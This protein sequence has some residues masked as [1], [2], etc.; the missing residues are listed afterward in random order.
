[1]DDV[2]V[3]ISING[4]VELSKNTIGYIGENKTRNLIIETEM[5]VDD[6]TE[7]YLEIR[8]HDKKYFIKIQEYKTED[9]KYVVPIY[10]SILKYSYIQ[11]QFTL[12]KDDIVITKSEIFDFKIDNSINTISK[13]IPEDYKVWFVVVDERISK[14]ED[15]TKK[16]SDDLKNNYYTKEETYSKQEVDDKVSGI[17]LKDYLKTKDADEK[18]LDKQTASTTYAT[19]DE[20]PNTKDFIKKDVTDLENYYDKTTSDDKYATKQ[21]IPD[22]KN[23][24]TKAVDDLEN[25]YKKTET[26]TQEEINQRISAIKTINLKLVDVL[27]E[28]GESNYIY[29]V[30]SLEQEENN[31]KNEYIWLEEEQSFELI[32]TTKINLDDYINTEKLNTALQDY[33]KQSEITFSKLESDTNVWELEEGNYAV[34]KQLKLDF[35]ANALFPVPMA[36]SIG[37]IICIAKNALSNSKNYTILLPNGNIYVG[38]VTSDGNSLSSQVTSVSRLITFDNEKQYSV[39]SDYIPAHKNY[40]DTTVSSKVD[41]ET[42]DLLQT[43]SRELKP[44]EENGGFSSQTIVNVKN[45]SGATETIVEIDNLDVKT[46][47]PTNAVLGALKGQDL[48]EKVN[49]LINSEIPT[50]ELSAEIQQSDKQKY[51]YP[52]IT[53]DDEEKIK[54]IANNNIFNMKIKF[55]V[56]NGNLESTT[57]STM[58]FVTS[59]DDS[60]TT[61]AQNVVHNKYVSAVYF[62]NENYVCYTGTILGNMESY[63]STL[64]LTP[65]HIE[66]SSG[67]YVTREEFDSTVGNMITT[68][69]TLTSLL[70]KKVSFADATDEELAEILD[71]HYKGLINIED[72]WNVGDTRKMHLSAMSSGTGASES[73][74]EQDMTMVIIGFNHDDLKEPINGINKSAITLQCKEVLGNNG[75]AEWVY[76][77]GSSTS[78][79]SD[80]NYSKNPRRTWLNDTFVNSLPSAIQPLVKTVIKKNINDHSSSPSAGPDTEDKAFLTSYPEMFGSASY[81]N[82][83]GS[84]MLEGEQY[85]YYNSNAKR[86]KFW[87]KNGVASGN[88]SYYW[89]R[90]PSSYNSY[91]WI[92]VHSDGSASNR[93]SND[94]YGLAPAFCL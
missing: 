30:P 23:F 75:S 86:T 87:N 5:S 41:E 91:S 70:P 34:T 22:V 68:L 53:I 19:K 67:D 60:V 89:L 59:V 44:D 21:E 45:K 66:V 63:G 7:A 15:D 39:Y 72:Y 17:D 20:I 83:K 9:N 33:A 54:F 52:T 55:N 92:D 62:D 85:P 14:V 13:E 51:I 2:N 38:N 77:W 76:I 11:M 82:Y 64:T 79:V 48:D 71:A 12:I 26:Y 28:Q 3:K 57:T 50:L 73:H 36:M 65:K 69:S 29:L 81:S 27:P 10:D 40:V 1:M 84:V 16:L 8:Q 56:I 47:V 4:K 42:R 58:V 37:T 88:N 78:T 46:D 35:G 32:G 31:I 24:I 74:V 43:L 94:S 49:Q 6:N 61:Q 93:N 90:S 18:F 80:S 25:Y